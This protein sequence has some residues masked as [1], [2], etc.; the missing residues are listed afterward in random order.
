LAI[1]FLFTAGHAARRVPFVGR[2]G[3]APHCRLTRPISDGLW[4]PSN[5]EAM[6]KK[7]RPPLSGRPSFEAR[8]S[9]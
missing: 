1:S 5:I 2:V 6:A 9:V 3:S 7:E 4:P 8:L